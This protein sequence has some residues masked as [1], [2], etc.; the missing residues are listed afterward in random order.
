[1][2][3][4]ERITLYSTRQCSHCRQAK[5]YLKQ[6]KISFVEF[7]IERNR[8]AFSDF[9]RIGGRGVPV[10]TIGKQIINGFNPK[11]LAQAL[12]QAGFSV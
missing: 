1:M 12:C 11:S 6:H 9:Q 3:K 4:A 10:I 5:A 8:R 2:K 7:D